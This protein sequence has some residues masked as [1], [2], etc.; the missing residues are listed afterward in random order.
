MK[1]TAKQQARKPLPKGTVRH[2][3][4]IR[5]K[6][7]EPRTQRDAKTRT[8]KPRKAPALVTAKTHTDVP[9]SRLANALKE[10]FSLHV[11]KELTAAAQEANAHAQNLAA[12]KARRKDL[13]D[14]IAA[15]DAEVSATIDEE[16][17]DG[18][19][20][21]E[22]YSLE[23]S[24][25]ITGLEADN[26]RLGVRLIQVEEE[27]EGVKAQ[28]ADCMKILREVPLEAAGGA[29]LFNPPSEPECDCDETPPPAQ[30]PGESTDQDTGEVVRGVAHTNAAV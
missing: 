8:P 5:V 18:R 22:R 12:L 25:K 27:I 20:K 17:Q 29:H 11:C 21:S 19:G 30:R 10:P 9:E 28:L 23:A 3:T 13:N 6:G 1:K 15:N 7:S 26:R 14:S 16:A 2:K 4:G 24:R